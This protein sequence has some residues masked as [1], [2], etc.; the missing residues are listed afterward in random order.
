MTDDKTIEMVR[1]VHRGMRL[2]V[3]PGRAHIVRDLLDKASRPA[4]WKRKPVGA[5]Y[6]AFPR[7]TPGETTTAEYVDQF[8][9]LNH[10][11]PVE[12]QRIDR[13]APMLDPALPEVWEEM[14]EEQLPEWLTP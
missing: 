2:D 12:S 11:A 8:D 5:K 4:K 1:F 10:L 13:P 14:D 9:K 6:F 3:L 7:F